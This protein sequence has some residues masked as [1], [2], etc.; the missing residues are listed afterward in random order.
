MNKFVFIYLVNMASFDRGKCVS[1]P[2]LIARNRSSKALLLDFFQTMI[3]RT[4]KA[5]FTYISR[6][7]PLFCGDSIAFCLWFFFFK[8]VLL[9][10]NSDYYKL[11][12]SVY[13]SHFIGDFPIQYFESF[14]FL[15]HP[16]CNSSFSCSSSTDILVTICF[17][18]ITYFYACGCFVWVPHTCTAFRS[19]KSSL[20]LPGLDL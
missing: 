7:L 9:M 17:V 8:G 12:F 14:I 15:A 13:F 20:D 16:I 11:S 6:S 5:V 2:E 10:K 18:F 3:L 1:P 19:Q 4:I